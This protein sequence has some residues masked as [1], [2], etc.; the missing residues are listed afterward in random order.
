MELAQSLSELKQALSLREGKKIALVPTMGALHQGHLSLVQQA[1]DG[2]YFVVVS[3]FVNPKQFGDSQDFGDYPRT[4]GVDARLLTDAGVDVLFAPSSNDVYPA[5]LVLK[6]PHAGKLAE[7]FEGEKR[8]GHFDG[9]LLVVNRL[10]DLVNPST[11]FFGEKDLQQLA[12]VKQMVNQQ[13]QSGEREPLKIVA[14][15]TVRDSSGLALSSRNV[16]ILPEHLEAAQSLHAALS[17][18]AKHGGER[19]ALLEAARACLH[20]L[21]RLDYLE[22]VDPDSFEVLDF[23]NPQAR[24]IVAAWVG[25]VRLIDNLMIGEA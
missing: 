14:C 8:P 13:I 17:A 1:I 16:R 23:A 3:V 10:F 21:V 25:E 4:L 22:L 19:N 20:P 11:A 24:L 9:M 6:Q 2:G 5:G 15:K 18:G 12:L 7:R